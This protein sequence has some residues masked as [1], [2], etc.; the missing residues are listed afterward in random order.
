LQI[1]ADLTE[2]GI[3]AGGKKSDKAT[4]DKMIELIGL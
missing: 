4:P 2:T 3:V 1:K